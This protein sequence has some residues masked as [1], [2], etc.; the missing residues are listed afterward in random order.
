MRRVTIL[1]VMHPAGY[2]QSGDQTSAA[3][4]LLTVCMDN[5]SRYS[6]A[7]TPHT[8]PAHDMCC[9][10]CNTSQCCTLFKNTHISQHSY[11]GN[12]NLIL[13]NSEGCGT[14]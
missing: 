10:L 5:V 9:L 1:Y 3:F 4:K 6:P 8:K 2:A 12:H 13:P 7:S 14:G 11:Y